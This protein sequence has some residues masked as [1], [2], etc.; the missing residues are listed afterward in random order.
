[1]FAVSIVTF[2]QQQICQ[3]KLCVCSFIHS[4]PKHTHTHTTSYSR[5]YVYI[6]IH[7]IWQ[8]LLSRATYVYVIYTVEQFV[9]KDPAV[10]VVGFELTTFSSPM[11][12]PQT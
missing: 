10:A 7:D 12:K 9:V 5:P 8:L 3:T 2:E 1:M 6:Y 11:S 4:K